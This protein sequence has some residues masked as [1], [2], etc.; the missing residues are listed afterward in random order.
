MEYFLG[1]RPWESLDPSGSHYLLPSPFFSMQTLTIIR[2]GDLGLSLSL[3]PKNLCYSFSSHYLKL[4]L[5]CFYCFLYF[6]LFFFKNWFFYLV[7]CYIPSYSRGSLSSWIKMGKLTLKGLII[8]QGGFFL[9]EVAPFDKY[10]RGY[11]N[12]FANHPS[13][14]DL[15]RLDKKL[16]FFPG[17]WYYQWGLQ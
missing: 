15:F 8:F 13:N 4:F 1:C 12:P 3:S 16:P 10:L 6:I 5:N 14:Q 11:S 17:K 9:I 7:K 2:D